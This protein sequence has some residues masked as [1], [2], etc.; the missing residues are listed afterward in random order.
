MNRITSI[1]I[2]WGLLCLCSALQAQNAGRIQNL[3]SRLDSMAQFVSGLTEKTNITLRDVPVAEYVRAIGLQHHVNV[4]IEDTPKQLMTSNLANESVQSVLLFVCK[5]FEYDLSFTGTIIQFVPYQAPSYEP[6]TVVREL[7]IEYEQ[8]LLSLD[9]KQDSL[10]PVLREISRLT[11]RKIVAKPGTEGMLTAYLPPTAVDTA[12]EALFLANGFRL[13]P[14]RKGYYVLQN[15]QSSLAHTPENGPSGRTD[16]SVEAFEDGAEQ[17]VSV[18]AEDADLSSLLKGIFEATGLSYLMYDKLNGLVSLDADITR[19]PDLLGHLFRGTEYTYRKDGDL[20]LIGA[21]TLDGLR[22][23]RIVRMKYRPTFQAIELI[24]GVKS[25]AQSQTNRNTNQNRQQNRRNP[26]AARTNSPYN[27]TNQNHNN[28][29]QNGYQNSYGN[30]SSGTGLGT[31]QNQYGPST[32]AT[33]PPEI[34]KTTVGETEIIEYPELNRI[35]LDGPTDQIDR[36]AWFLEQIDRP[37]PMVKVEMLVV[38]VNKDRMLN[39]GVKAGLK[40]SNDTLPR[41]QNLLPGVNYELAGDELNAIL[42]HFPTLSNLGVLKN[43]FYVQL[44]AQEI[45]GNVKVKMQPVLSMLNGR[46]AS[47]VIGQTQYYLLETQTASTGAVNNFQTFTQRFESI[48]ASISLSLKPYISDDDMV[49]LEVLPDFTTPVGSFSSEVPPTIATR[50]FDSIIRVKNGETVILGGLT[51]E[52]VR[53]NSTGLPLLSRIPL[54]RRLTG[55]V[56]T[57]KSSTSLV[58]FIT[59]TIYYH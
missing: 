57:G 23:T 1:L 15:S 51:Q 53:D 20:F 34:T 59:P 54:L 35:I 25:T 30:S 39:T 2:L 49:T 31:G 50:R 11:G 37:V 4:F 9:L 36:I 3:E 6:Q 47:L 56:D 33:I 38:E 22:S 43:N 32:D 12:L 21:K 16:F 58:I 48:E 42:G 8:G 45:Q 40:A 7:N 27:N 10:Y 19:L 41:I 28:N 13:S 14:R 24:P 44:R 52:E 18:Q 29:S 26:E 55:N 5:T 17:F 46:S